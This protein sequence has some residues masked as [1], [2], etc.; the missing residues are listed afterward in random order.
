[1]DELEVGQRSAC[2]AR[3]QE[4]V[5]D[6]SARVRRPRPK[7]GVTAGG[8]DNGGATQ[9]CER[10][11]ALALDDPDPGMLTRPYRQDLREVP[12]GVRPAGVH[13]AVAGVAALAAESVVEPHAQAPELRDPS[14]SLLGQQP[15]R[16]GPAQP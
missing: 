8:E 3:E 5:A 11:D 7:S 16:A 2:G 10:R 14:R 6:R 1:L 15:D 9:V 4:P 13:D 12:S